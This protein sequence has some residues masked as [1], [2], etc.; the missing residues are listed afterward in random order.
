MVVAHRHRAPSFA[1]SPISP[2][3]NCL[4]PNP[5]PPAPYL[6]TPTARALHPLYL[7]TQAPL[8]LL[9]PQTTSLSLNPRPASLSSPRF[10][11]PHPPLP[12]LPVLARASPPNS[13]SSTSWSISTQSLISN[14]V[15]PTHHSFAFLLTHSLT[16]SL[17]TDHHDFYIKVRS[18]QNYA[19]VVHKTNFIASQSRVLASFGASGSFQMTRTPLMDKRLRFTLKAGS[20]VFSHKV[21]IFDVDLEQ[22]FAQDA[23]MLAHGKTHTH[24]TYYGLSV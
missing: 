16:Y 13:L 2:S 14:Q 1:P 23:P 11:T 20:G 5:P 4:L 18:G 10:P 21:A 9:P 7:P 19:N 12:L 22:A 17:T 8:P 15:P 6:A 3:P 24:T